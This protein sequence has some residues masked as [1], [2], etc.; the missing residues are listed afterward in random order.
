MSYRPQFPFRTPPQFQDK[1]FVHYFDQTT[2]PLFNTALSLAAGGIILNIPLQ[3]QADAPF[4]IR[5]IKV[6]GPA[7]FAVRFRDP[8]GNYLS[9]GFIPIPLRD[10]PE[11]TGVY[12]SNVVDFEPE[13]GCPVGSI[14]FVDIK[15]IS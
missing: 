1:D 4:S 11:E 7:N 3:L 14:I 10:G 5:G 12:G 13:I 9:E 6:N 15:R 8:Y 2:V